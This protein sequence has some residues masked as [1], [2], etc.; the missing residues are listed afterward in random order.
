MPALHAMKKHFKENHFTLQDDALSHTSK[1]TWCKAHFSKLLN[2]GMWPPLLL[3]LNALKFSVW[4]MLET[5]TCAMRHK[6]VKG[7]KT[8]LK[9]AWNKI[10]REAAC[11][12]Y[13]IIQ[14]ENT[15]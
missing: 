10:L 15:V 3:D 13:L 12:S 8:S 5:K 2:K 14:N 11:L 1:N 9:K 7:L 6:T 4:F